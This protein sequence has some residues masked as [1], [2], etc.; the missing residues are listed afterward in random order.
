MCEGPSHIVTNHC[1]LS[2][3]FKMKDLGV[4]YWFL[5]T[6]FKC[7]DGIEMNQTHYIERVLEKFGMNNS[8][9]TITSSVL[10]FDKVIDVELPV[11]KR[12]H[13]IDRK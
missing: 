12:S 5:G 9:P 10:G 4:L 13:I 6:E 7:S 11:I 8:K 3:K 1:N 2:E